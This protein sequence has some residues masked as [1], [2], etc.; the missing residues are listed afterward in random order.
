MFYLTT[1]STHFYLRLYGVRHVDKD[2]SDAANYVRLSTR[3]VLYAHPTHR[4]V[5]TATSGTNCG[6]L[7]GTRNSSLLPPRGGGGGR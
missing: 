3:D 5:H 2:H 1:Y 6:V 7:A 4:I